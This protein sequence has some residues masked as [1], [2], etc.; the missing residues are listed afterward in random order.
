MDRTDIT[1]LLNT[2]KGVQVRPYQVELIQD[3]L[4]YFLD[5]KLKSILIESPTGSGK[6]LVALTIAKYLQNMFGITVGWVSHR[7]TLLTQA[8]NE[9]LNKEINVAA[10]FIS[11][12][13]KNPPGCDLLIVDECLPYET[14]VDCLI[15][16][17]PTTCAIGDIVEKNISDNVMSI[18]NLGNLSYNKIIS[19][20]PMGKKE[21]YLIIID[22]PFGEKTLEITQ[23]GKLLIGN[24]YVK[25][26]DLK[27]GMVTIHYEKNSNE[28]RKST[29][30]QI[31]PRRKKN[32]CSFM[33]M[34]LRTKSSMEFT[35]QR[36]CPVLKVSPHTKL[37]SESTHTNIPCSMGNIIWNN[38]RRQLV[39]QTQENSQNKN[40]PL[41]SSKRIFR[42][43]KGTTRFLSIFRNT[44]CSQWWMGDDDLLNEYNLSSSIIN[45]IRKLLPRW[46]ENNNLRILKQTNPS[47]IS[48]MVYGRRQ[49]S[50]FINSS[51]FFK[52]TRNNGQ[53]FHT[54]MESNSGNKIRSTCKSTL[55]S[56]SK[57]LHNTFYETNLSS[58]SSDVSLQT[59]EVSGNCFHG[60]IK[61]ITKTNKVVETYDIGVDK[62]KN[63]FAN[64]INVHNCHHD[65]TDSMAHIHN[66]VRPKY[67]LGM[68][69][70]PFRS[71]R[72]KLCFDKVIKKAGIRYLIKEGYLSPYQLWNIPDWNVETVINTYLKDRRKWG[73][74]LMF[75]RTQEECREAA[76]LLHEG[77]IFA[78]VVTAANKSETVELFHNNELKVLINCMILTEG[79][80]CLSDDSEILTENG[81]KGIGEI[82]VNDNC[83]SMNLDTNKMELTPI[84]AY[85]ERE[86]NENEKLINIKSQHLDITVTEGHEFH[87]RYRNTQA[88]GTVEERL[89]NS[90]NTITGNN[91]L[92]GHKEFYIPLA[93]ELET[94]EGA[95]LTDDE[96]TFI[97]WALTDG[98]LTPYNAQQISQSE[99]PKKHANKIR[100][101]LNRLDF[102][103]KET[104]RKPSEAGYASKYGSIVFYVHASSI[105]HLVKY[106]NKKDFSYLASLTRSQFKT[107]WDAMILGNGS[108]QTAKPNASKW[109]WMPYKYQADTLQAMAIIRGFAC[110]QAEETTKHGTKVYRLSIRDSRWMGL[111]L[112]DTRGAKVTSRTKK[113][114]EK[115]WCIKNRNSTLVVRRNGKTAIIGN[116]PTLQ[117]VFA[118]PSC[119]SLTI[120]MCGRVF[121]PHKGIPLKNIV[122]SARSKWPFIKTALPKFQH[123]WKNGKWE[124]LTPNENIPVAVDNVTHALGQL[125]VKMPDYFKTQLAKKNIRRRRLP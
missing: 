42:M 36:I 52:R 56:V 24:E 57:S 55:L 40:K 82:K 54:K 84:E 108:H 9:N 53:L 64:G 75:F 115:V 112:R 66:T 85:A 14:Q 77:N 107:L 2:F 6:S 39:T 90:Y 67:I 38:V 71:D 97:G 98:Y 37:L 44:Y 103:Y 31:I 15:N 22:T 11:M 23:E 94:L 93:A 46:L 33:Q 101:L 65:S 106:L 117:T 49:C 51:L 63:F 47:I 50:N 60:I 105:R 61:S 119:K 29:K 74:S 18:D 86:I 7:S 109:L 12:F 69:A 10:N 125:V 120:Q 83:Y 16:N 35:S 104:Y 32:K 92:E 78:E 45:S 21:L 124:H 88:K 58:S 102:E 27:P 99:N 26:K 114:N 122:Q 100:E 121:R 113:E 17:T 89:H 4:H 13:E 5:E 34:R 73:K 91:L 28:R 80:D 79:F 59:P 76:F 43:E 87:I 70:T 1:N 110:N 72:I 41:F 68:T 19:R 123:N 3:T 25:V 81:W 48:N 96:L 95:S 118:K 20:T 8:A 111:Y 62:T 30:I 116:C